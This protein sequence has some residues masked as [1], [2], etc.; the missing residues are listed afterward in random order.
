MTRFDKEKAGAV[1][2]YIIKRAGGEIPLRLLWDILEYADCEH[3]TRNLRTVTSEEYPYEITDK[4][5]PRPRA[6]FEEMGKLAKGHPCEFDN[7]FGFSNKVLVAQPGAEPNRLKFSKSDME[8][9]DEAYEERKS[10]RTGSSEEE[11]ADIEDLI[12]ETTW[13]VSEMPYD[14]TLVEYYRQKEEDERLLNA[15]IS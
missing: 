13:T 14:E 11:Y 10:S 2:L 5:K 15:L 12:Q 7:L 9:L 4:G 3:F 6:I 8:T 1:I